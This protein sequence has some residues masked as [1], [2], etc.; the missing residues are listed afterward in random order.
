MPKDRLQTEL[1]LNQAKDIAAKLDGASYDRGQFEELGATL[2]NLRGAVGL[3]LAVMIEAGIF[4]YPELEELLS[5]LITF[6]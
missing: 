5:I 1:M 2:D 4:T 6:H 3:I